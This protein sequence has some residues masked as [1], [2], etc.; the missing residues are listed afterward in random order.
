MSPTKD[1][2]YLADLEKRKMADV[3]EV[4]EQVMPGTAQI[5]GQPPKQLAAALATILQDPMVVGLTVD[6]GKDIVV[7]MRSAG[8]ASLLSAAAAEEK[9]EGALLVEVTECSKCHRR[10]IKKLAIP[11]R[12]CCDQP[13]EVKG[14]IWWDPLQF[15]PNTPEGTAW[16][17]SLKF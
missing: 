17:K 14:R 9:K 5:T 13:M 6:T 12:S 1:E 16:I 3:T 2:Q 11:T 4:S 8:K 15:P 7:R 10:G